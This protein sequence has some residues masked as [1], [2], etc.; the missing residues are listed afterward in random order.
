MPYAEAIR[1]GTAN[2]NTTATLIEG[3]CVDG[4][5]DSYTTIQSSS[6]GTYADVTGTSRTVTVNTG[7]SVLLIADYSWS[8]GTLGESLGVSWIEDGSAIGTT[9]QEYGVVADTGGNRQRGVLTY[10][11][12]APTAGSRTYKL[13]F[14]RAAGSGTVYLKNINVM[15]FVFQNR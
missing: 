3:T 14:A 7:D 13:K 12:T 8:A 2:F 15:V 9:T 10:L 1:N 11:R 6:S 5:L 4:N